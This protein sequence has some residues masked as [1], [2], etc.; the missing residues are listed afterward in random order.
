MVFASTNPTTARSRFRSRSA[1]SLAAF[2]VLFLGVVVLVSWLSSMFYPSFIL[3]LVAD[4]FSLGVCFYLYSQW[5]DQ[6]V[7][8]SCPECEAIVLSNTPWVCGFCTRT[9]RNAN[10]FPFVHKCSHCGD[11]AKSYR[12]HHCGELIFLTEDHD[13]HNYAYS[14][15]APSEQPKPDAH[16][17]RLKELRESKEVKVAELDVAQVEG[18]L[19][20]LQKL[21]NPEMPK[22]KSAHEFLKAELEAEVEWDVAEH[23]LLAAIEKEHKNNPKLKRRLKKAL[24]AKILGGLE[25][26]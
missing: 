12:C 5:H 22:K 9:N 21:I 26:R 1:V 17:E 18:E 23:A 14:V 2:I 25:D 16:V 20:R 3:M 13:K 15:N 6:P 7:K 19:I 4:V 24:K 11:E 8:L 10:A